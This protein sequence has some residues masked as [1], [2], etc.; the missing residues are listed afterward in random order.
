MI[1]SLTAYIL[2]ED[3]IR[4][5]DG[6][7][8]LIGS[9]Y[10]GIGDDNAPDYITLCKRLDDPM[11][12]IACLQALKLVV[13]PNPDYQ[14]P[15]DREINNITGNYEGSG[16]A[17]QMQEEGLENMALVVS[18]AVFTAAA[19]NIARNYMKRELRKCIKTKGVERKR[20]ILVVR[21]EGLKKQVGVLKT[22]LSKCVKARDP[23][24]CKAK[25]EAKIQKLMQQIKQNSDKLEQL[26]GY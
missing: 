7:E 21:I 10:T 6:E 13:G 24:K 2:L 14:H 9:G 22:S 8:N 20:C 19:V 5:C 18:A 1:D 11:K 4:E 23:Q 17:P 12:Q 25:V 26:K 15:I 16:E 3:M